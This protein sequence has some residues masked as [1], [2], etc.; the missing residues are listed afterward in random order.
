M[1]K[2]FACRLEKLSTHLHGIPSQQYNNLSASLRWHCVGLV[3]DGT[4]MRVADSFTCLLMLGLV[5]KT[6]GDTLPVYCQVSSAGSLDLSNSVTHTNN[7]S[8][9]ID[10]GRHDN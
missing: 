1:R 3:L 6:L 4:G 8:N 5:T 10:C 9:I 7:R 2:I